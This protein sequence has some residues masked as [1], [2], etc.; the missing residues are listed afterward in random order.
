MTPTNDLQQT[1]QHIQP[2]VE[3]I[4]GS[5]ENEL[6]SA[7]YMNCYT[8]IYDYCVS[9][10][11]R[12]N[13]DHSQSSANSYSLA[14]AEMYNK[15]D[16]YLTQFVR[17]LEKDPQL[18]FLEFY[19]SKWSRFTSGAGYLNN[20]FDYMNRYWVQKERSDGRKDVYDV[21]TL[22]L[23][24]WKN[25]MFSPNSEVLISEVLSLIRKSRDNEIIDT[26]LISTAI[27]SL[28]FLSF[29]SQDSKKPGII[30]YKTHFE[31]RYL[32]ETAGYYKAESVAYL[33]DHSVVDYM[34]K[35][36]SRLTE[37]VSRSNNYLDDHT[38]RFLLDTL[39]RVLVEDHAQEMYDQFLL[40]LEQEQLDDIQRMYKLLFRVAKTIDPL[41]L[42]FE[43]YI[44]GEAFKVLQEL[45]ES[46]E[47]ADK[48]AVPEKGSRASA[49]AG[50]DPKLYVNALIS[51]YLKFNSIVDTAFNK[52]TRFI[53]ALDNACRHF[54]NKNP[55]ATP[56]P[57]SA[58]K[59][60][61]LLAKY[62]DLFL[63]SNAKEA[64]VLDMNV[65]DMMIVFK[66]VNDK[67]AFEEFYRRQLA[68]RLI[69][70]NSKSEELEE[71]I[72]Q[73]LQEEN[74]IEYTSKMTK[75]FSDMKASQDLK[76]KVPLPENSLVKDFNPLV[77]AQSMWPFTHSADYNLNI[78]T[79]LVDPFDRIVDEYAVQHTGRQ[80]Q[81]LWNHGRAEVKANLSKKGK[82][83]FS[84]TVLNTQLMILIAYNERSSYTVKELH[85]IVGTSKNVFDAHLLPLIKYKLL[86]PSE[87]EVTLGTKLTIVEE[88]KSK[89][90]KV[91][92]ISV[93][94]NAETK[95]EDDE[96]NKEI[97]ETRKNFLSACIVRIMKLRK[98]VKHND[99][100]NE[101]LPQTSS[102]FQAKILDVK[103]VIDWLIER[104][105]IRR[106]DNNT[107]EY[108]S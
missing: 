40:L 11:R 41:A 73:R 22:S 54:V 35:C 31:G 14:G 102:R 4:L 63:K 25:E 44:K 67:D 83:P 85:T 28:I 45:A 47:P 18:T 59:T 77:L 91:N 82:P 42:T 33:K 58:C 69:N 43:G 52:D 27:K 30:V 99:L 92:F 2:G 104:Q 16:D 74:S 24:K 87:A 21:N 86:E 36:E 71:S 100:I 61:E 90:M 68:K 98:S 78:G 80:L 81:W 70:S 3:F 108:L 12:T 57:K 60:P 50:V 84:F 53:K 23:I 48:S 34:Y 55:I 5:S 89:K 26:H 75:M 56:T 19:V 17:A 62:S 96:A 66:F 38:K 97:D 29:E 6:T 10:S 105:Y 88:Y 72:I 64:D 9:K 103:R 20:V 93:I 101:V 1:W 95:Q 7:M 65:D 51:I 106:V 37:E 76:Y 15:L 94:K 46:K 79:D 8:A 32:E 49:R 107:Y 39:N 13:T